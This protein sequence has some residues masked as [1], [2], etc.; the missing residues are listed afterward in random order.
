MPVRISR[1]ST[2]RSRSR[3]STNRKTRRSS[4]TQR[5]RRSTNRS[6]KTRKNKMKGGSNPATDCEIV[7]GEITVFN[8]NE[9]YEYFVNTSNSK[10]TNDYFNEIM[11]KD[12]HIRSLP[13]VLSTSLKSVYKCV[14]TDIISKELKTRTYELKQI[15]YYLGSSWQISD[16][17]VLRTRNTIISNPI[18]VDNTNPLYQTCQTK[19]N[20]QGNPNGLEL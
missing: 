2:K 3:R 11:N 7:Y 15:P 4:R 17:Y 20:P 13:S 6:S 8:E 5:R 1:R 9:Y 18:I 12:T 19:C 16:P 10:E 14:V